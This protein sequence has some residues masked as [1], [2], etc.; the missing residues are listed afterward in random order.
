MLY[1]AHV[2]DS[3]SDACAR[4]HAPATCGLALSLCDNITTYHFTAGGRGGGGDG[5]IRP[6]KSR[7][8]MRIPAQ[9]NPVEGLERI[10]SLAERIASLAERIRFV[11]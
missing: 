4:L 11:G 3:H 2:C 8:N 7:P 10:A 1:T 9:W 5:V 6:P